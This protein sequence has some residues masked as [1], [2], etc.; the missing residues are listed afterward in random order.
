[1]NKTAY[2]IISFFISILI[3]F[4]TLFTYPESFYGWLALVIIILFYPIALYKL[5]KT[6]QVSGTQKALLTQLIIL[7]LTLIFAR[8]L[9][10][11]PDY[12]VAVTESLTKANEIQEFLTTTVGSTKLEIGN[13]PK[14]YVIF[15]D[16]KQKYYKFTHQLLNSDLYDDSIIINPNVKFTNNPL[17]MLK[18]IKTE[19]ENILYGIEGIT[20]LEIKI[21]PPENINDENAKIKSVTVRY[22]TEKTADTQ[23]IRKKVET[24]INTLFKDSDAEIIIEDLETRSKVY[25]LIVKAQDEFEKKNYSKAI[26]FVKEASKL[27]DSYSKE[28]DTIPKII[29]LDKKTKNYQ[30]YIKM[31]DL[32]RSRIFT[33]SIYAN[34]EAVKNYEKALELNPNAPEIYQKIGTAYSSLSMGYS[35]LSDFSPDAEFKRISQELR[36]ISAEYYLKAIEHSQGENGIYQ[37]LAYYYYKK[38]DYNKAAE[39]YNKFDTQNDDYCKTDC[40]NKKFEANLKTGHYIK[41]WE[42]TKYCSEWFCR[43]IRFNFTVDEI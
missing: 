5:C 13:N 38:K 1:M 42:E 32:L 34:F 29:E 8:V 7:L 19:C 20:W 25:D 43:L 2:F 9:P 4:A 24:F 12:I 40:S 15:V 35:I 37:A 30:D 14:S 27:D 41:A 21:V 16:G 31:G 6:T 23:K 18:R 11:K 3:I 28:I 22:E 39:Y 36:D 17:T 10:P 26:E 33:T